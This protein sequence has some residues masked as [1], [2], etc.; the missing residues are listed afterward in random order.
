[1]IVFLFSIALIDQLATL[2]E[3]LI[4]WQSTEPVSSFDLVVEIIPLELPPENYLLFEIPK[5]RQLIL[6]CLLIS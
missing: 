3:S 4:I 2:L 5:A 1:M 6:E